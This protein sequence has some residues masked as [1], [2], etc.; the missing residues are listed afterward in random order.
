LIGFRP[1]STGYNIRVS[2]L[3]LAF[4]AVFGVAG[5]MMIEGFGLIDAIYMTAITVSTVGFGEVHQLSAGGKLFTVILILMT[6]G[7]FAYSISQVTTYFVEG[8][9]N[10][11]ILGY[12]RKSF[13]NKMKDHVIVVGFGRNGKKTVEELIAHKDPYVVVEQNLE[14]IKSPGN[15]NIR[16]VEGDATLDNVL[17][18]AGIN[19]ARALITTLPLDADNLFVVLTARSLN[20]KL[21][22][23]SRATNDSAQKK[24]LIAGVD[25]VVMPEKVGGEHMASLV[26][27]PDVVEFLN[28]I[29]I[30][31]DD[32]T[33]LEEI[34]CRDLDEELYYKSI[35]ELGVRVKYGVN[36]IGFKTPDGKFV[37]NPTPETKLL[38]NSKL[39]V[40]GTQSQIQKLKDKVKT[41]N[42]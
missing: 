26:I 31:G 8:Q 34:Y 39:F 1:H 2:F 3:L 37:I 29:S 7:T 4:I 25:S 14:V 30:T 40:L 18:Q 42:I 27:K 28:H 9:F 11:L 21:N 23:I 13:L 32:Q 24:L 6:L 17:E 12:R 22:I 5:F 35:S 10:R 19:S 36:I 38:P 16:F 20:P 15:Q 33:N 41:G